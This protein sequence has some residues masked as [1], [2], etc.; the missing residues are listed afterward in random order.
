M[1]ERRLN[2]HAVKALRE[3]LGIPGGEFAIA[4]GMSHGQL[5][6]I[7]SGTR[8][9]ASPDAARRICAQLEAAMPPP[10]HHRVQVDVWGAITYPTALEATG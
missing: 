3:L 8:K 2:G 6:N 4:C 5:S 9:Q 7:E 1:Q 10:S